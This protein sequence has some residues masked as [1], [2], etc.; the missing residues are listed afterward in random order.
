[1]KDVRGSC[2]EHDSTRGPFLSKPCLSSMLAFTKGYRM[3]T[4][5]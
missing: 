5:S 3:F 4:A 1:M 2:T